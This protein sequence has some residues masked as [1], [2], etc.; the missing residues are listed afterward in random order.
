MNEKVEQVAKAIYEAR[1]GEDNKFWSATHPWPRVRE[2]GPEMW[3]DMARAAIAA[4]RDPT[5]EMLE[6]LRENGGITGYEMMINALLS[7]GEKS[8]R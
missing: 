5:E 8:A 3:R 1:W 4:M 2:N 6:I 7:D